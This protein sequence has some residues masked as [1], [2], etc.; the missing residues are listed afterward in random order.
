MLYSIVLNCGHTVEIFSSRLCQRVQFER[1][2]FPQLT[3]VVLLLASMIGFSLPHAANSTSSTSGLDA[4]GTSIGC[5]TGPG[6]TS[7]FLN[8]VADSIT[9]SNAGDAIIVLADCGYGSCPN[10]TIA[11]VFD[12][13]GLNFTQR[14]AYSPLWE[15]YAFA[16]TTLTSDNIT[17]E[18]YR[19]PYCCFM[20][21]MVFA[22]SGVNP[23][24]VFDPSPSMPAT[25]TCSGSCSATATTSTSDFV[26]AS[27][28]IGDGPSC[29]TQP[30]FTIVY[31]P[32]YGLGSSDGETDWDLYYQLLSSPQNLTFS[33]D[34]WAARAMFLDAVNVGG[35]VRGSSG[36]L[37]AFTYDS[38]EEQG[39]A[40]PGFPASFNASFS[41]SPNGPIVL[42]IWNFGDP[43][44]SINQFNS[45]NP[46]AAHDYLTYQ[47]DSTPWKVT[48]TVKDSIG[49]S[50]TTVRMVSPQVYPK[51]T[52]QPSSP[53]AGEP[54]TFDGSSS[55]FNPSTNTTPT[56]SWSFGDGTN[57]TGA[58]VNHTYSAEGLYR[59][60]LTFSSSSGS[61]QVSKTVLVS[62]DPPANP[63]IGGGGGRSPLRT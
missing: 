39:C 7:P 13:N 29:T 18:F 22:I 48:L 24:A 34:S 5:S 60:M 16:P 46:I 30:G 3:V 38:C 41:N 1:H 31:T 49:Q 25:T 35:P 27:V 56:Y 53:S 6:T 33:C 28:S 37:A 9:T 2:K 17:V 32:Y 40:V 54:V 21:M 58:V 36:P 50:D 42:Y 26:I 19:T 23:D 61:G 15:Y 12:Q 4:T 43:S 55:T 59:V 57:A 11:S 47:N 45:T 20:E 52:T 63:G 8:C 51:F 44:S 14:I 62:P 10:V